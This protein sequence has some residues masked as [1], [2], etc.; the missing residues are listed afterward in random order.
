MHTKLMEEAIEAL[1]RLHEDTSVLLKTT[2][3]SLKHVQEHLN[4]LV[5]AAECS[6]HQSGDGE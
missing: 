3:G 2:V 6:L 4:M 1:D 5:D